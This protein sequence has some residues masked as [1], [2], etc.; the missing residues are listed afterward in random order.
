MNTE[1]V[2]TPAPVIDVPRAQ[3][4]AWNAIDYF[5]PDSPQAIAACERA[6]EVR[7]AAERAST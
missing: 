3:A 6:H 5:G 1:P 2:Q 4:L 7:E